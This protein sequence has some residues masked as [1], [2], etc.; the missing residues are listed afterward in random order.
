[1][2]LNVWLAFCAASVAVLIIPG[3]T[4]LLV[5]SYAISQGR[6]VAVAVA[7]GVALGDLL[8]MAASLAG[9]GWAR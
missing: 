6:R 1:M 5:S 4:I 3:P 9:L 8:A 7:G 2:D